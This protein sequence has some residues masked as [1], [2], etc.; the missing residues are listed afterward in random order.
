[1]LIITPRR[2]V[3]KMISLAIRIAVC[4]CNAAVLNLLYLQPTHNRN[5]HWPCHSDSTSTYFA[6]NLRHQVRCIILCVHDISENSRLWVWEPRHNRSVKFYIAPNAFKE[7]TERY[8]GV[9]LRPWQRVWGRGTPYI[10]AKLAEKT[11]K[12]C[13][14]R[15]CRFPL[16]AVWCAVYKKPKSQMHAQL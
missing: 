10:W 2:S 11:Y 4:T 1:M 16:D 7:S 15:L 5:I 3:R 14:K 9:K 13:Q 12:S 6:H 8:S